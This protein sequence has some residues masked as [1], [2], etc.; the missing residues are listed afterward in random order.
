V[1]RMSIL[2]AVSAMMVLVAGSA[3]LAQPYYSGGSASASATASATASASAS[4]SATAGASASASPT[5][6]AS[7]LP[8][9]G[10]ALKRTGGPPLAVPIVMVGLM[11]VGSGVAAHSL[12]RRYISR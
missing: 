4:T 2:L 1:K 8:K 12:V 9:T 6:S 7:A 11:L 5:A 3:A 10:A